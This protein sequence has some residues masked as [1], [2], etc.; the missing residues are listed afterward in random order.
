MIYE[1]F[2]DG[3]AVKVETTGAELVSFQDV[4]GLEYI[5]QGD[6]T[7]WSKHSPV[8]FPIVGA[9]KNGRYLY[10]GNEYA[11]GRHG[12]ARNMEFEVLAQE[13]S[14]LLLSLSSNAQ[15][16]A[17]YPFKFRFQVAFSLENTVLAVEY[18][19]EN[20]GDVELPFSVGGHTAYNCPL[21]A[22]ES[23][24]EYL[25]EFEKTE[26]FSRMLLSEDGL[27]TGE[28]LPFM[29]N[30]RSFALN[31]GLFSQDAIVPD[32]LQSKSVSLIN[33]KTGRGVQVDY[34]DFDNLAVW[35]QNGDAPFVCL[36]PWNGR[37]SGIGDGPALGDKPGLIRLAPFSRYGA[38]HTISLL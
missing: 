28:L 10:D 18:R 1:L 21:H 38:R 24:E 33:R 29:Q 20:T 17:A 9:Q 26:S 4:F 34:P 16:R 14:R 11:I 2:S 22:D 15:T 25:V 31:H 7:H 13:R 30:G 19:V 32:R 6:G 3:A 27:F 8:L 12:F 23:F 35:S 37:A 36:E 5:W